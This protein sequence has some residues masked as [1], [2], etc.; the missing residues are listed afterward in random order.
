MDSASC[1]RAVRDPAGPGSWAGRGGSP[2][3]LSGNLTSGPVRPAAH[4]LAD[5]SCRLSTEQ[6]LSRGRRAARGSA[7]PEY[8]AASAF[9]GLG[10]SATPHGG[11]PAPASARLDRRYDIPVSFRRPRWV[12][13]SAHAAASLVRDRTAPPSTRAEHRGHS[14]LVLV[15]RPVSLDNGVVL[16]SSSSFTDTP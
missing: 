11:C 8:A 4:S 6:W 12:G 15:V 1:R 10:H 16:R 9:A 7:D 13:G 3:P 14:A 2:V 5:G